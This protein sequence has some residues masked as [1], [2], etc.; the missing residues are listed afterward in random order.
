[1]YCYYTANASWTI[2][3]VINDIGA[4]CSGA[5]V[6]AL[7]ASCNKPSSYQTGTT[8]SAGWT[9][10][11]ADTAQSTKGVVLSCSDVDAL[12]TK[13]CNIWGSGTTIT[14]R[15]LEDWNASLN[16]TTNA[17][18]AASGM[19]VGTAG[20]AFSIHVFCTPQYIWIS[21]TDA[22]NNGIFCFELLR[23]TPHLASASPMP[24][25]CVS[26]HVIQIHAT[27]ATI[28]VPRMR[29]PRTGAT[30]LTTAAGFSVMTVAPRYLNATTGVVQ[31]AQTTPLLDSAGNSFHQVVPFMLGWVDNAYPNLIYYGRIAANSSGFAPSLT[32]CDISSAL[33]GDTMVVDGQNYMYVS[34]S[35]GVLIPIM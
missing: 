4:L 6:S 15:T 18:T 29:N 8:I 33:V 31:T 1:M 5:L 12:T 17:A 28:S 13:Y 23:D 9:L 3:D 25:T 26:S 7:S 30:L 32:R 16:T 34:T 20:V 10:Y 27:T 22:S 11:D 24:L 35:Y 21:K 2:T 19:S 14:M